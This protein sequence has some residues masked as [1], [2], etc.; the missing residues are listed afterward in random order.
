MGAAQLVGSR[1]DL[2]GPVAVM[3]IETPKS[4][5][6]PSMRIPPPLFSTVARVNGS[7]TDAIF[8]RHFTNE[9]LA[10]TS[11]LIDAVPLYG[12]AC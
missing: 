7:G 8:G 5:D 9:P 1:G 6:V 11:L 3:A 12:V 2:A 10:Q 4:S